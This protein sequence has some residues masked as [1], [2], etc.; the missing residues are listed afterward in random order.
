MM[1]WLR[2]VKVRVLVAHVGYSLI[3][4]EWLQT[5]S[6]NDS[7]MLWSVDARLYP[8]NISVQILF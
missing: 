5:T 4:M 1:L 6:N 2:F 3:Y 8:R 7:C